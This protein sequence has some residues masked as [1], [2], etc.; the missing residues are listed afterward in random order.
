MTPRQTPLHETQEEATTGRI[1]LL[2][3]CAGAL[4]GSLARAAAANKDRSAA[5][6]AAARGED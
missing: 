3:Y 5:F 4:S 2:C 6:Y 1:L